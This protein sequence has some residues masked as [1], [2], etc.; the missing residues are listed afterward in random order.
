ML[1][2]LVVGQHIHVNQLY[3]FSTFALKT[4]NWT[5]LGDNIR[6]KCNINQTIYN[7]KKEKSTKRM[8]I[9]QQQ[10]KRNENLQWKL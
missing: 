6:K 10:Q 9:L 1:S 4:N 2:I 3:N 5:F 7:W 8:W